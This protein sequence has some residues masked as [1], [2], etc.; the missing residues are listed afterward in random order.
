MADFLKL[1]TKLTTEEKIDRA[2]QLVARILD[3]SR[4]LLRIHYSNHELN[5]SDKISRQVPSSYAAHTFNLLRVTQYRFEIMRLSALWDDPRENRES[6]PTLLEFIRDIEVRD[7]LQRLCAAQWE[8]QSNRPILI[9]ENVDEIEAQSIRES[10]S[11][12]EI[13]FGRIEA[14]KSRRRLEL[15]VK[16]ADLLKN[17]KR[18]HAIKDFRHTRLAHNLGESAAKISPHERAKYGD[19]RFVLD[20]TLH[21]VSCLN[22][23]IR[24]ASFEWDKSRKIAERYA[25]AFWGGV[26]LNVLE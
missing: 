26:N 16:A 3:H 12:N 17:S 13:E 18:I 1:I 7:E 8:R 4:H 24:G 14:A 15:G 11:N 23:G 10:I 5:Y 21:I 25:V 9:G 19:E 20:R 2:K 6:I 22:L